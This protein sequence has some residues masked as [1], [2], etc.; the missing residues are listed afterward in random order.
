MAGLW[1]LEPSPAAASLGQGLMVWQ[2]PVA[3]SWVGHMGCAYPNHHSPEPGWIRLHLGKKSNSGE[4]VGVY[5]KAA[6]PYGNISFDP[7]LVN[8]H[9]RGPQPTGICPKSEIKAWMHYC[10]EKCWWYLGCAFV[11]RKSNRSPTHGKALEGWS[12]CCRLSLATTC[13][14]IRRY[15]VFKMPLPNYYFYEWLSKPK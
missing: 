11:L 15:K 9:R 4:V 8:D 13:R 2:L 12:D 10:F 7:G 3:L 6:H 5:V 14:A 1:E